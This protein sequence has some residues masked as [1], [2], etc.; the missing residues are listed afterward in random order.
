MPSLGK[1]LY[2]QALAEY[3]PEGISNPFDGLS[4][5]GLMHL[6]RGAAA[7]GGAVAAPLVGSA[8]APSGKKLRGAGTV[9]LGGLQG[10]GVGGIL[11]GL[12]GAGLGALFS[13]LDGAGSLEGMSQGAREWGLQ[14]AGLGAA[15]GVIP[16]IAY[17]AHRAAN[18]NNKPQ[19]KDTDNKEKKEKND[20][21]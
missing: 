3:I 4:P 8:M 20:K 10:A 19:K 16:G 13:G 9:G 1:E 15:A 12:G 6:L 5:E 7:S 14:G 17:G 2:K 11:G 21:D 18:L